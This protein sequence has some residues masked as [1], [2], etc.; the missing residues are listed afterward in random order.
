M[1]SR[2]ATKKLR[3]SHYFGN[4]VY[5]TYQLLEANIRLYMHMA[6]ENCISLEVLL[7]SNKKRQAQAQEIWL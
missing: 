2:G 4:F 6:I 7:Y 5:N 3:Q 1:F